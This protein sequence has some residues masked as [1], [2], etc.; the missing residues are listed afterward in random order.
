MNPLSSSNSA[1]DQLSFQI[2]TPR[3]FIVASCRS[4]SLGACH[5]ATA[6]LRSNKLLSGPSLL[7]TSLCRKLALCDQSTNGLDSTCFFKKVVVWNCVGAT[8][9]IY[10]QSRFYVLLQESSC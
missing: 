1:L 2:L 7:I 10:E 3:R 5:L 4:T 8:Q 6:L 9:P